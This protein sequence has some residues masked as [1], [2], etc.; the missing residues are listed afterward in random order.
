MFEAVVLTHLSRVQGRLAQCQKLA[1]SL[2]KSDAVTDDKSSLTKGGEL[3]AH[4]SNTWVSLCPAGLLS[5]KSA[6]DPMPRCFA[7]FRTKLGC[8]VMS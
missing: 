2:W 5:S 8:P 6:P 4:L 3:G 7:L 1:R